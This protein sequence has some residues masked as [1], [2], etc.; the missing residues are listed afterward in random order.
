MLF[1]AVFVLVFAVFVSALVLIVG[2]ED[3]A[4]DIARHR[5]GIS[6]LIVVDIAVD[7]VFLLLI[8]IDKTLT[9]NQFADIL[10]YLELT[11]GD[12]F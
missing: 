3:I 8:I 11:V 2:V 12:V 6:T 9:V 5:V 1:V 4:V 7:V 10:L